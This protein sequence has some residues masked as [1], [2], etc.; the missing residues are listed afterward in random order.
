MKQVLHGFL[1]FIIYFFL[2]ILCINPGPVLH[3]CGSF[4]TSLLPLYITVQDYY[5]TGSRFVQDIS[6]GH[7]HY[8]L[9]WLQP[10]GYSNLK[11]KTLHPTRPTTVCQVRNAIKSMLAFFL[12]YRALCVSLYPSKTFSGEMWD[13]Q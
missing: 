12:T 3:F 6:W 10:T 13:L 7:T 4:I 1:W 2:Y 5:S 8:C 9:A 11:R